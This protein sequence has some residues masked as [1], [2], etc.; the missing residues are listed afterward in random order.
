MHDAALLSRLAEHCI[1]AVDEIDEEWKTVTK[2]FELVVIAVTS[3][4]VG[5]ERPQ[6]LPGAHFNWP[7]MEP[8]AAST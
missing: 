3:G 8:S 1:G 4:T 7:A 2:Y 5:K 6:S